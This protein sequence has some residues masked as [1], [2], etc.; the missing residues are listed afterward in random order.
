MQHGIPAGWRNVVSQ[1]QRT[2]FVTDDGDEVVA[3]WWGDSSG[4]RV[5][6]YRVLSASPT[7]VVLEVDGMAR[8]TDVRIDDVDPHRPREVHV[9]GP[10]TYVRLTE[11]PR[12]TDPEAAV[13]AGSLLAAMPGTVVRVDVAEGDEVEAGAPVLV[14]EAMKMQHTVTRADRRHGHAAWRWRPGPRWPPATSSP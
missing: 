3:E 13:S 2:R 12:F 14:L 7:R 8:Q 1:P 9:D 5:D 11:V 4:Y 6:G 10:G